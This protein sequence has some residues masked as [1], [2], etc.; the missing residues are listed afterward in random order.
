M[1]NNNTWFP[2]AYD[3]PHDL[4]VVT[5]LHLNKRLQVSANFAYS[6]GRPISLPEY[7]YY[8]GDEVV[9]YFSDKNEYRIP[10]YHR[11]DITLSYDESLRLK[12][13]WKGRWS[14]SLLNVYGRKNAYTIYYKK[15]DPSI[16]N[17]Y[18]RFSQY[19][20]YLIGRPVPTVSYF[21]IF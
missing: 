3:M 15:E 7:K 1:I 2:S 4:S 14:F 8:A 13:R 11:L 12:K 16:D 19:K 10:S 5:N 6:S 21:F 17:D 18:N 9:V 20:L